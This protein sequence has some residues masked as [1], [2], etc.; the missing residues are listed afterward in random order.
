MTGS[1]DP[2][3]DVPPAD[4]LDELASARLDGATEPVDPSVADEVA[5]R[6]ERFERVRAVLADAGSVDPDAREAAIAAALAAA[7]DVD[8]AGDAGPGRDD[9][10]ER[11]AARDR[12]RGMG[13]R[14]AGIAA[15]ALAAVALGAVV[16]DGGGDDD[17]DTADAPAF[18]TAEEG[19]E[20]DLG[21]DGADPTDEQSGNQRVAG[22]D[23][24]GEFDDVDELL[25]AI[26][27]RLPVDADGEVQESVAS[28]VPTEGAAGASRDE[29][30]TGTRTDGEELDA[31]LAVA[32]VGGRPVG[33]WFTADG[34]AVVVDA[35]TCEVVGR[36]Q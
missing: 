1:E 11:R 18:D 4:E 12:R 25:D 33:V 7:D 14:V 13:L 27:A 29:S 10:A 16:L 30:C 24:L 31:L 32:R 9:L 20:G 21:D 35:G 2:V 28:E 22:V 5:G 6:Q 17:A 15:A 8:V 34:D 26:D 19:L 36:P 3:G 23:D